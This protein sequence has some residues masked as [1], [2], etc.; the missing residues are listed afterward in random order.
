MGVF[1]GTRRVGSPDPSAGVSLV[2]LVLCPRCGIAKGRVSHARAGL[3]RDCS[4]VV[5]ADR[6]AWAA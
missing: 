3:C 4:E 5:G 6:G 2:R 1:A